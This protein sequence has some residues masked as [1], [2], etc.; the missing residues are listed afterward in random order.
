M[1]LLFSL[2][3]GTLFTYT[4]GQ[5]TNN[6]LTCISVAGEYRQLKSCFMVFW[7]ADRIVRS[8]T[9]VYEQTVTAICQFRKKCHSVSFFDFRSHFKRAV[10]FQPSLPNWLRIFIESQLAACSELAKIILKMPLQCK[11]INTQG[12]TP[13]TVDSAVL[14][15]AMDEY[16]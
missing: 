5:D 10:H 13:L 11:G 1:K 16:T 14:S 8:T 4:V 2:Y 9:R 6:Q 15:Q 3:S 7:L 12:K